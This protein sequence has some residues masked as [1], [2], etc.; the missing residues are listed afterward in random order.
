M[1]LINMN[2]IPILDNTRLWECP[3]CGLQ[4]LTK[5][6]RVIT[7]MHPCP[8]LKGILAPYVEVKQGQSL[9]KHSF[10]HR[11]IE[12]ED[13]VGKESGLMKDENGKVV[14]AVHT[15][16]S[17]GHDTAVFPGTAVLETR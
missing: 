4:H 15:E 8:K 10:N 17:S 16:N 7:P 6:Q 1:T 5:D 14:M 9:K 13:Y 12:R 11:V 3:S 2:N